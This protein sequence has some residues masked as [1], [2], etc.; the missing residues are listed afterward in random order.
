LQKSVQV[1]ILCTFFKLKM[2]SKS[3]KKIKGQARK[4][5]AKAA[6]GGVDTI[7]SVQQLRRHVMN[8]IGRDGTTMQTQPNT[9]ICNLHGLIKTDNKSIV[10]FVST[11]FKTFLN[12]TPTVINPGETMKSTVDALS[13]AY[14]KFPEAINIES[15]REIIK[16][17]FISTGVSYL[18]GTLGMLGSGTSAIMARSCAAALMFIDSYV[19]SCPIPS[20][21][22]DDRDAKVWLRNLDILNGC[23]HSLVKFFVTRSLCNCLD[24]LY[25]QMKST[26]PKMSD[27][28]GCRQTKERNNMFICTGCERTMYCSKA[29]QIS[30]VPKHKDM[31]KVWQKYDS[32]HDYPNVRYPR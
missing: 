17:N 15:N 27:C 20:G 29:C 16:N 3:R 26:T 22:I 28:M 2:P 10:S 1:H 14:N 11:F 8:S 9:C 7:D 12:I 4:A 18:L 13:E 30:N 24:E 6:A 25:A 32:V 23:R 19:P 31:C 5:K 21:N